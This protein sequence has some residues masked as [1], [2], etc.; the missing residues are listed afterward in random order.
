MDLNSTEFYVNYVVLEKEF[1]TYMSQSDCHAKLTEYVQKKYSNCKKVMYFDD[2]NYLK[3]YAI[4]F[5]PQGEIIIGTE[6][7]GFFKVSISF[8]EHN[9]YYDE[10]D[11]GSGPLDY[12]TNE[13][14]F[15]MDRHKTGIDITSLTNNLYRC[16]VVVNDSHRIILRCQVRNN[17]TPFNILLNDKDFT[18][19]RSLL[20]GK[21]SE[22]YKTETKLVLSSFLNNFIKNLPEKNHVIMTNEE[23]VN[24]IYAYVDARKKAVA[25]QRK[26]QVQQQTPMSLNGIIYEL[27]RKYAFTK[28]ERDLIDQSLT[29]EQQQIIVDAIRGTMGG[30]ISNMPTLW[31]Q[32]KKWHGF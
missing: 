16:E 3:S 5:Y 27:L 29:R 21:G 11:D 30:M 22:K 9:Y 28:E 12:C 7:D 26:A 1:A 13:E 19:L 8:L 31:D 18:I 15:D 2:Y 4:Y 32:M 10:F 14:E 25:A 20:F 23:L 17:S 24:V 6:S